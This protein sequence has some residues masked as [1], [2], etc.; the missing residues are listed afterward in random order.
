MKLNE[1]DIGTS[2]KIQK[3]N[4]KNEE[5]PQVPRTMGSNPRVFPSKG[6]TKK[7][8]QIHNKYIINT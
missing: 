3:K 6:K 7:Q 5:T 1:I 4:E 2:E 8:E